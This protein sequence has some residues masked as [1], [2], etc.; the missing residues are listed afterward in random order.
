MQTLVKFVSNDIR[1]SYF[2]KIT[3]LDLKVGLSCYTF[4]LLSFFF[5]HFW[6]QQGSVFTQI[7]GIALRYL[8]QDIFNYP[9]L[10][11]KAAYISI[12]A[13]KN[14]LS[15]RLVFIKMEIR[16]AKEEEIDLL[17]DIFDHSRQL[18]RS[19]GNTVQWTNGY[20]QREL[21]LQSIAQGEQYVF[22]EE[23]ELVGTFCFIRGEDPDPNYAYIEH[24]QWL[25]D[26]PYGVIH[27]IAT[28]G[29]VKG[30]AEACFRWC[31]EQHPNIRVD[32]YQTNLAM[33]HILRKL[34]YT[35]CG[36]I[37]VADGTPRLAFHKAAANS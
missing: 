30:I 27:R 17:M 4:A 20:P 21:I 3:F 35:E 22:V 9:S 18:M 5:N 2:V 8:A 11:G 23:D 1:G 12:S 31:F 34:G 7:R 26:R 36:I 10:S 24:G 6:I 29:K 32:T 19:N 28:N 14:P 25:N 33:Q 37:Y 16:S 15:L 13:T